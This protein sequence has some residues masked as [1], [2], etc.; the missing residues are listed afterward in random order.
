MREIIN[1][2]GNKIKQILAFVE[3]QDVFVVLIIIMVGIA[4]FG[5]GR[6]SIIDE[7]KSLL[8]INNTALVEIS[9]KI[10]IEG[11]YVASKSGFK[12]H[13]PWCP[14]AQKI[15]DT[16]K[17]WFNSEEEAKNRGYTPAKNC[18]GI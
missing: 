16:N 7:K 11:K 8:Q 12:Y 14:G 10:N 15:S 2:F 9:T 1:E 3:K 18:K 17:I 13:L 6:L 4:S 5:L